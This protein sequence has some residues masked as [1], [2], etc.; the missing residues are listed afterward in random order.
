MGID[1]IVT[2]IQETIEK[3]NEVDYLWL[4]EGLDIVTEVVSLV[5][6][7]LSVIILILVP[8]IITAEIIYICFPTVR[9][10]VGQLLVKI[11]SKGVLHSAV[12][13]CLRDA[14]EAVERSEV[15]GV[16]SR[17]A[18]WIYLG[19]KCKSMFV[20]MFIIALVL[21]GSNTIIH[22]VWDAFDGLIDII[23]RLFSTIE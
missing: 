5:L 22:F 12:G 15:D 14:I 19:L 4:R 2:D 21:Q 7:Y 11:E 13:V 23:V 10:S 18:L 17:S 16:G 6:G 8:L 20:L 1:N 3:G 9:D